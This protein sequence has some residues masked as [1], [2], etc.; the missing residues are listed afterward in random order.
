MKSAH[1]RQVSQWLEEVH[2]ALCEKSLHFFIRH[3]WPEIESPA[4]EFHDGWHIGAMC[5]HLEAVTRGEIRKLMIFVPPR[6]MKSLATSVAWPAWIWAQPRDE[7]RPLAGPSVR[8]LSASYGDRLSEGH[9]DNSLRVIRSDKYLRYWGDR[10]QLTDISKKR[11]RNTQQGQRLATSVGGSVTGLGGDI[12][13]ADDLMK[14]DDAQSEVERENVREW[15]RGTWSM[16]MNNPRTGAQVLIMQRL[17]HQDIAGHLLEMGGWEVLCLPMRYEPDHPQ[18]YARDPRKE[19]GELLWP[20]HAP[21]KYVRE[22]EDDMG[23]YITAGQF[24]QRPAPR[25]GGMFSREKFEYVDAVPDGPRQRCRGW[26]LAGSKSKTSPYTVGVLMSRMGKNLYVEHVTRARTNSDE[27]RQMMTNAARR[28]GK[29]VLI[30][31]PQDPGQAG[32]DQRQNLTAML[33]GYKVRSSPES[34]AKE[35]RADPYAAQVQ[36]GNVYLVRAPWNDVYLDE[37]ELF[38]NSDFSDQVDASSRAFARLTRKRSRAMGGIV[39]VIT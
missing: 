10:V 20:S 34:G 11:F 38:P 26:D 14:P 15:V 28:D 21:E 2:R 3:F 4:S 27:M 6:S 16:R 18:V 31:F 22:K 36:A 23:P 24:Q 25:E 17:H 13:L 7:A 39:K 33:I 12:L 35:T 9:S 19:P 37:L 29:Q 30:D 8:F 1:A 32:K 5:E